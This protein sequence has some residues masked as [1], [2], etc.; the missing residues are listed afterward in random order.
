M[1]KP[2][3]NV[4][5]D[6]LFAKLHGLWANAAKEDRLMQLVNAETE[7]ELAR[8]LDDYHLDASCRET[9]QRDLLLREIGSLFEISSQL[10]QRLADFYRAFIERV[11]FENIKVLLHY[12]F[13]PKQAVA[14]H[15]LMVA[16]PGL[17]DIAAE[18]LLALE[19]P[20]AFLQGLR[21][22]LYPEEVT[23]IVRKLSEDK[24]IMLSECELDKLAYN[25]ILLH[26]ERTPSNVRV[27][28]SSLVRMEIDIVN[29][30]MLMRIVHTY[31]I[32]GEIVKSM[33]IHGGTLSAEALT[34]LSGLKS[35]PDLVAKLPAEFRGQLLPYAEAELYM[36]EN[37]L[38]KMLYKK[39]KKC[40]ADYDH[41]E[42]SIVA[43]PFLRHFETLNIGRIYEGIH[44]GIQ[45]ND[46][47]DMIISL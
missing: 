45:P 43:F 24:D 11:Y 40:F 21:S 39:A 1:Q 31:H 42:L 9:F 5:Y 30:C 26:A 18:E 35:L 19:S 4:S 44:Y 47:L 14:I 15:H 38:W 17:P 25:H 13:F 10:D 23:A 28:C 41:A 29:L 22:A 6:F 16:V 27:S 20:E 34:E 37:T 12:Q 8:L 32:E 33:W 3:I 7:D 36:S 2:V 46:M